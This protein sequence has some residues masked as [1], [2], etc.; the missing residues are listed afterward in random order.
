M[1]RE[2]QII[3]GLHSV[4]RELGIARHALVLLEE[5]GGVAA[6]ASVLPVT[7]R[8][9]G[10]LAP[11]SAAAAPAAALTIVDQVPQVLSCGR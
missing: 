3:F 4:A 8:S 5:L 10:I 2:L 9:T 11:L 7:A 1:L 6:L